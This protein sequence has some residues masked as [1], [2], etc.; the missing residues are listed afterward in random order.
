MPKKIALGQ[1]GTHPR[2]DCSHKND[3][4]TLQ[5]ARTEKEKIVSIA[6]KADVSFVNLFLIFTI[7]YE[8]WLKESPR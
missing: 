4:K 7:F 2:C 6:N 8:I 5:M 1:R 3:L